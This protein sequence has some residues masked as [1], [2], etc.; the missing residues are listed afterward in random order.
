MGDSDRPFKVSEI[1]SL[2]R[3]HE[4]VYLG[5]SVDVFDAREGQHDA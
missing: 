2:M 3:R 1:G 5:A 4:S